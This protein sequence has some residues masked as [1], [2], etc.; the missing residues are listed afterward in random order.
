[1]SQ[2]LKRL[3]ALPDY[4]FLSENLTLGDILSKTFYEGFRQKYGAYEQPPS[5]LYTRLKALIVNASLETQGEPHSPAPY[6][7]FVKRLQVAV[8]DRR[9][10]LKRKRNVISEATPVH[11]AVPTVAIPAPIVPASSESVPASSESDNLVDSR[12]DFHDDDTFSLVVREASAYFLI[13]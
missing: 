6:N 12:A 9:K 4:D 2:T 8:R 3:I 10:Y 1:M 5:D 11:S 7:D 13:N